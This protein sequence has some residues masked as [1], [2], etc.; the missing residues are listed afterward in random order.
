MS[1]SR[2]VTVPVGRSA[3]RGFLVHRTVATRHTGCRCV[4]AMLHSILSLCPP[5]SNTMHPGCMLPLGAGVCSRNVTQAST[6]VRSGLLAG[7]TI[8]TVEQAAEQIAGAPLP[9]W[10]R[11]ELGARFSLLIQMMEPE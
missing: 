3:M 1:V 2:N 11:S 4:V 7:S 8:A 5:S 6:V 9:K 10:E